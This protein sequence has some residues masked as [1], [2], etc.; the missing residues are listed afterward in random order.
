MNYR[1]HSYSEGMSYAAHPGLVKES[2]TAIN[3]RDLAIS[4]RMLKRYAHAATI[5]E[6]F[7][8]IN[9]H[10]RKLKTKKKKTKKVTWADKQIG[11]TAH[12]SLPKRHGPAIFWSSDS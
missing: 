8:M 6:T 2:E 5:R 3:A 1:R 12:K 10:N 4:Q 7:A 11:T 9:A